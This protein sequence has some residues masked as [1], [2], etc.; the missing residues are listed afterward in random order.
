MEQQYIIWSFEH[1]AWWGPNHRGYN[2]QKKD[3]G[4][5][6]YQEALDICLGANYGFYKGSEKMPYEVMV[7]LPRH[8]KEV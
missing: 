1:D 7:P 6:S 5:Y 4:V 2:S 8:E 3:A